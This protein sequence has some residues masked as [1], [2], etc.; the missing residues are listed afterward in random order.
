VFVRGGS[1]WT[2]EATL[3]AS[4]GAAGDEL[5]SS[6]S[7]SADGTRALVGAPWD[8]T[9]GGAYTGSARVFTLPAP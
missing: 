8:D 2:E 9:A 5:G 3:L 6:V 4:D 7:L 1:T